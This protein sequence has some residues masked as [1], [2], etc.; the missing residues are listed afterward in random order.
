MTDEGFVRVHPV[1][2]FIRGGLIVLGVVG[3]YVSQQIDSIAGAIGGLDGGG[4]QGG[5]GRWVLLQGGILVLVVL[6]AVVLGLTSWWFTRYRLGDDSIEM[7]TGALF[8]QHR[9]VR[10]DRIQAVDIVRPLLARLTG[11]SEVRVESAG[12]GDSHLS[13]A[14]LR[15]ADAEAMRELLLGLA[16]RVGAT[17]GAAAPVDAGEAVGTP[18]PA[19]QHLLSVPPAR[20][21]ASVLLSGEAIVIVVVAVVAIV[22]AVAGLGPAVG[23]ALP[24]LVITAGRALVRLTRWWGLTVQL[25]GST[26]T[27]Q[28]GLTDTRTSSVPLHRVQA[29]AIEQPWL[30]RRKGWWSLEVNVAGAEIGSASEGASDS[31][32]V[33]V[34]TT[35]E[36]MRLLEVL[37]G[38]P[39]TTAE[40]GSLIAGT[41]AD[42]VGQPRRARWLH[43]FAH[44]RIGYLAGERAVITRGGWLDHSIQ[45]VP[46][47]RIQS[48]TLAQGPLSRR[49]D[50]ASAHFVSTVGP[51]SPHVTHL[52]RASIEALRG[53]TEAL[54]SRSRRDESEGSACFPRP[55][56]V[57]CHR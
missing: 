56:T 1:S 39:V 41:P 11:L 36:V 12:G 52:D 38:D 15:V 53:H 42:F 34:A 49:L 27:S 25:R 4:G 20:V 46:W 17:S 9:Q 37:T 16:E 18:V 5:G 54:A 43:P 23:G 6:G 35:G 32:L 22:L 8:R 13:I 7:H 55:D 28:R 44:R 24:L 33:P 51:V 21:V 48:L 47:G 19:S 10:Y 26:L 45:I 14:Y 50:L 57:D 2:P 29:V 30:W 3:Y 40:V 31:E